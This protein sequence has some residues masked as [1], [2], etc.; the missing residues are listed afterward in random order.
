VYRKAKQRLQQTGAK[1]NTHTQ[2]E[3]E[4]AVFSAG[5]VGWLKVSLTMVGV[6]IV[7]DV[8]SR[9]PG[10]KGGNPCTALKNWGDKDV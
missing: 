6:F 7:I 4:K 3:V 10:R 1:K 8:L 5:R 2:L 9:L